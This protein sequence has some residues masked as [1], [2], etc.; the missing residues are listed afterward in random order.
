MI[1]IM[2]ALLASFSLMASQQMNSNA[3]KVIATYHIGSSDAQLE[4]GLGPDG[5]D[6]CLNVNFYG[7]YPEISKSEKTCRAFLAKAIKQ[8]PSK[9]I[10]VFAWHGSRKGIPKEDFDDI[11]IYKSLGLKPKV[12]GKFVGYRILMYEN[13]IVKVD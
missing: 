4:Q 7:Q 2:I 5:K 1:K 10:L 8:F 9:T 3:G 12:P 13:G 6:V 11:Q